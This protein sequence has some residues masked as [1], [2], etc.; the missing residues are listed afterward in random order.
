GELPSQLKES[1]TVTLRKEAKKDYSLPGSYRPIAVENAL[2]KVIE[3]V[4]AD[5]ISAAAE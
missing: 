5:R 1:T 4:V 3:K 2:T